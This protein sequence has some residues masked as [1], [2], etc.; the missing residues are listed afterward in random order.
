MEIVVRLCSRKNIAS[1]GSIFVV[2]AVQHQ[3]QLLLWTAYLQVGEN[4]GLLLTRGII[5]HRRCRKK[6]AGLLYGIRADLG[7]WCFRA[8]IPASRCESMLPIARTA[9]AKKSKRTGRDHCPRGILR[10]SPRCEA[11]A[12][13]SSLSSRHHHH[14]RCCRRHCHLWQRHRDRHRAIFPPC[15]TQKNAARAASV[16][17]AIFAPRCAARRTYVRIRITHTLTALKWG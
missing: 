5:G 6:A 17:D 7:T 14:R 11:F 15:L 8:T 9:P 10:S 16:L 13:A 4:A 12:T 1:R 2:R 3:Y